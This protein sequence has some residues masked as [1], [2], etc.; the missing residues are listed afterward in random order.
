MAKAKRQRR[1]RRRRSPEAQAPPTETGSDQEEREL[2]AS[3]ED[4][5]RGVVAR[6]EAARPEDGEL[7]PGATHEI[8]EEPPGE[9]P[10]IRRRRF[11]LF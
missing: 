1:V 4:F 9:L 10:K 7:P 6:D 5:V 11:S 2:Q 8:V 3:E